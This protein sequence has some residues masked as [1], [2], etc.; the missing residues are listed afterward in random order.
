MSRIEREEA[1]AGDRGQ[2]RTEREGEVPDPV[3]LNS[4]QRRAGFILCYCPNG[5]PSARPPQKQPEG[6]NGSDG[7]TEARDAVE[8]N[9]HRAAE[10]QGA[11]PVTGNT[12]KIRAPQCEGGV[13]QDK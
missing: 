12:P 6:E 3:R 10:P 11:G 1:A 4:K 2:H 13:L 9:R 7:Q 5:A 8:R